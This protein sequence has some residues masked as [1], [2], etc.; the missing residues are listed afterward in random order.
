[1]VNRMNEDDL[2]EEQLRAC[3]E[4]L[5]RERIALMNA[6]RRKRFLAD[7]AERYRAGERLNVR[8]STY[9][10][11]VRSTYFEQTTLVVHSTD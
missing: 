3:L 7:Q 11:T 6:L 5:E 4:D 9:T 1:M 10:H 8:S 2:S